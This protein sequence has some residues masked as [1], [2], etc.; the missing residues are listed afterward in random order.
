M[1]IFFNNQVLLTMS[2]GKRLFYHYLYNALKFTKHFKIP[3]YAY[4]ISYFC[5]KQT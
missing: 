3:Y 5:Y 4:H 1:E 2:M